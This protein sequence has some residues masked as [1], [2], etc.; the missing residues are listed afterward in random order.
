MSVYIFGIFVLQLIKAGLKNPSRKGCCLLILLFIW[1]PIGHTLHPLQPLRHDEAGLPWLGDQLQT[2]HGL[3][4]SRSQKLGYISFSLAPNRTN[5]IA[6]QV[7][8]KQVL[9]VLSIYGDGPA[10]QGTSF[11][12]APY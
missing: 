5:S 9:G 3:L 11:F 8:N 4:C 1:A 12:C 10:A 7:L 2:R 6:I